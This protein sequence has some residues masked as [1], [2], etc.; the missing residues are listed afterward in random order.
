M[1]GMGEGPLGFEKF[2]GDA[3]LFA[4]GEDETNGGAEEGGGDGNPG[5]RNLI[6]RN[7]A[8]HEEDEKG[9]HNGKTIGDGEI[10]E[11]GDWFGYGIL[12]ATRR[13]GKENN[14][15]PGK[16]KEKITPTGGAERGLECEEKIGIG[17]DGEQKHEEES[18]G[19]RA[20][21]GRGGVA[22]AEKEARGE[23]RVTHDIEGQD[24]ARQVRGA[25]EPPRWGIKEVEIG[26][27]GN[28][29]DLCEVEDAEPIP[30][31]GFFVGGGKEHHEDRS[32][33][34]EEEDVRGHGHVR[35]AGDVALVV[36]GDG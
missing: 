26:G 21:A 5:K 6:N 34:N 24:M 7:G 12:A 11:R 31:A 19:K 27:D 32:G 16:E 20:K 1:L 13:G 2:L 10:A 33:P 22:R 9:D 29:G 25:G 8:P 17:Q 35:G 18:E 3:A 4:V 36:G 14:G 30:A 28:D 15:E 23:K